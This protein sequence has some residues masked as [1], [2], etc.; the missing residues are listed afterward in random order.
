MQRVFRHFPVVSK[1]PRARVARRAPPRRPALQG[2]FWEMHD[3]LLEDQGHL[4]EPHLWERAEHARARPRPLR[5]RPP[6]EAVAER[7][8]RDFRTGIRAGVATTPTLFVDGMAHPGVPDGADQLC[9]GNAATRA[10]CSPL[11]DRGGLHRSGGSGLMRRSSR[12]LVVMPGDARLRGIGG[13]AA[14]H[15]PV[16]G[17][18][19][20]RPLRCTAEPRSS[21]A[22]YASRRSRMPAAGAVTARLTAAGGRLGPRRVR[23]RHRAGRRRLGVSRRRARWRRATRS[24][25]SAWSSRPAGCPAARARAGL[26]VDSDGDRAPRA[27]RRS[28]LVRVSTPTLARRNELARPRPRRDRARRAGLPRGRAARRR[29]RRQAARP[30]AS[31]TRSRCRTSRCRRRATARPTARFAAAYA[32]RRAPERAAHLPAPVRLQR[33]H[34]ALAREHPDLVRPSR[35]TTSPTRDAR[36]R[37]SRSP[38]TRRARDGRPVFL[39]MGVHHAREWP[40]GEHAM[41]WAYELVLG[42]PPRRRAR[43]QARADARARSWCRSSTP[44][45]STPRARPASST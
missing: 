35:S 3:S 8:E 4:D 23:G 20:R 18:R 33:G 16:V 30:R 13:A 36:S 10:A 6:L 44:T 24:P 26:S 22:G 14:A 17:G 11:A 1:H 27:C 12:C 37:A 21:G 7:V 9:A 41:E 19:R 34:E 15:E 42:L 38:P 32:G 28:K 2:R 40:S 43:A 25:A 31:P 39:Q 45:A 5:G 29:R